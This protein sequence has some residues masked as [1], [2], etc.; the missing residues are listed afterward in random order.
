[1]HTIATCNII[2]AMKKYGVKRLVSLT[3]AGLPA[4]RDSAKLADRLI[5]LALK[6]LSGDVL[7][8]ALGHAALIQQSSP[9]WVIVRGPMLGDG[10]LTGKYH[11]GW[12]GVDTS[13]RISRG[14]VAD[15]L[16]KQT[17]DNTC[18]RQMA[19]ATPRP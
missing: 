10:P 1:M 15:F 19:C 14:D 12:V 18:P 2:A 6:T 9:D 16:L 7:Q 17:T 13:S 8:D 4:L 3:G 5:T 11:I